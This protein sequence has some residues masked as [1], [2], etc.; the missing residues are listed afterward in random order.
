MKLASSL[1]VLLGAGLITGAGSTGCAAHDEDPAASSTQHL[2]Q[3][4]V[5]NPSGVYVASVTANGTGCPAGSWQGWISDDGQTFLVTFQGYEATVFPGVAFAVKDCTLSINLK[6][7][8]G[9]SFA[10]TSF[11]HHG[12][13]FLEKAG[14]KARQ[15]AKYY[16]MGNPTAAPEL[17]SDISGPFDDAF[18]VGDEVAVENRVWSEC[19]T[20]RTLNAQTRLVLQNDSE[21]DGSGFLDTVAVSGSLD[22]QFRIG[23]AWKTCGDDAD[24]GP[25]PATGDD[26]GSPSNPP[27]PGSGDGADAGS[28][29][30][31]PVAPGDG[32]R[33]DDGSGS[34]GSTPAPIDDRDAGAPGDPSLDP[35]AGR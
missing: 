33:G 2:D 19:G 25:G 28:G 8:A 21:E 9:L 34:G 27:A 32:P 4:D 10:V 15:T 11:R 26:G 16:F 29:S 31:P 7:P 24:A 3:A 6:T 12:F 17:R 14:M 23:L 22:A 18:E 35:S 5:P 30:A 20:E 1:L 13:A